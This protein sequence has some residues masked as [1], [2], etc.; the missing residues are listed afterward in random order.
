MGI[1]K[2]FK[3][4]AVKGNVVDM[5]V[6][7][8]IGAAFGQIVTSLVSNVMMPPLG[9]L[10]S[11]VNISDWNVPLQAANEATKT[12]AVILEYGKFL[13]AVIDFVIKA[14]CVFLLVKM[15]N[16]VKRKLEEAPA[17]APAPSKQEVLLQEIRDILKAK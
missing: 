10:L 17:A 3:E 13:Q 15:I 14:F 5:A 16:R 12:P 11:G 2:E 7:I 8:I 4:F 6:G 1:V 9:I